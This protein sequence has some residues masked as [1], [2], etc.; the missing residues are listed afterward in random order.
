MWYKQVKEK[1]LN[2]NMMKPIGGIW[3]FIFCTTICFS[4]STDILR[5]EYT[6]LPKN[7]SEIEISRYRFLVNVPVKVG[8]DKYLVIGGEY[9]VIDFDSS[10][11]FP[12]DDSELSR[13]HVIDLNIGYIFKWNPNW[14]FV[15]II[16]PRLASN[17]IDGIL[18]DDFRLN[19]TATMWKERM[20]IEKPFRLVLGLT[21]NS[22]TG[23]PIPLPLINYYKRFH[24]NWS[25][26]LGVPRMNFKYHANEKHTLQTV[27]LLDGYFVNA[28]NDIVLPDNDLGSAISLSVLVGGVGYQ[29]NITKSMS[30]YGLAG[31]TISQRGLLRDDKRNNVFILNEEGS[32]Y[33]KAGF[34]IAIF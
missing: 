14:R 23:L 2:L 33:F 27:L 28:Q 18:I 19:L 34:K 29:Y 4:Q 10:R 1:N 24:P 7:D 21:Y 22:A 20:D 30:F 25:Y 16:T 15:S 8:L 31:Y 5:A 26:T 11:S 6:L 17:F 13:L 3:C 9:N 32:L 12:F